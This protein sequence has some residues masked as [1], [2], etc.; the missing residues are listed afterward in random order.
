M[1]TT[2]KK[3]HKGGYELLKEKLAKAEAENK[4]L[5]KKFNE[6]RE[7]YNFTQ[8]ECDRKDKRLTEEIIRA[9][10]AEATAREH[11]R[12]LKAMYD[13]MGWFKRMTWDWHHAPTFKEDERWHET[14]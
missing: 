13:H 10:K 1:E 8:E 7:R 11:E 4:E 12:Q 14:N 9:N 5:Q 6:E 2:K 3:K